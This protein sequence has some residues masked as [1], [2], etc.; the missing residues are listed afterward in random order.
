L[1]IYRNYL[2]TTHE[3]QLLAFDSFRVITLL[4]FNGAYLQ[5]KLQMYIHVHVGTACSVGKN[6]L[7]SRF[8]C[9]EASNRL[10]LS[11]IDQ[12]IFLSKNSVPQ[13]PIAKQLYHNQRL[14]RAC[15]VHLVIKKKKWSYVGMLNRLKPCNRLFDQVLASTK[16]FS[17]A[18]TLYHND[19]ITIM[20]VKW[21]NLVCK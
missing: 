8:D 3:N 16:L 15:I 9:Y 7:G 21:H 6:L 12:I 13:W 10:S 17:L 14:S 4:W 5:L 11:C 19:R 1:N 18:K 20:N 2:F